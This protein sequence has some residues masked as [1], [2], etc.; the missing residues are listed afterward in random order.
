MKRHWTKLP[1][2]LRSVVQ[3]V[4]EEGIPLVWD[5]AAHGQPNLGILEARQFACQRDHRLGSCWKEDKEKALAAAEAHWRATF[6]PHAIVTEHD[7]P[8]S[9]WLAA[10]L[11]VSR[12]LRIDFDGRDPSSFR[13]KAL[14]GAARRPREFSSDP[15][16][17]RLP[18][19]GRPRGVIVNYSP[20]YAFRYDLEG[21]MLE[22]MPRAHRLGE[23]RLF[24]DGRIISSKMLNKQPGSPP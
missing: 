7:R 6:T 23:A 11:G 15:D 24:M 3:P 20:V 19:F 2:E 9:I 12:I 16:A 5:R 13:D 18:A 22:S 4:P 17:Q 21:E 8:S 14:E 1:P 10:V